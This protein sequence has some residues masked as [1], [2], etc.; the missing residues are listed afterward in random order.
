MS[1]FGKRSRYISEKERPVFHPLMEKC[2]AERPTDRIM[3]EDVIVHL[4]KQNENF[5]V[6]L[7]FHLNAVLALSFNVCPC[8]LM[9]VA[10]YGEAEITCATASKSP[11]Q[12]EGIL[13]M[14]SLLYICPIVTLSWESTS[15]CTL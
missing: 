8:Y 11:K 2:L 12:Y 13:Y 7:L 6:R 5:T 14:I 3:F 10:N 4:R 1:E 15:Q 9:Y